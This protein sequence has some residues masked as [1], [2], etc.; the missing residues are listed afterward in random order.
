MGKTP[1]EFIQDSFSPIIA[2]LCS[3]KVENVVSKNNLSFTELL[4]PFTTMDFEG[5][6]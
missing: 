1:Q 5:I 2:I 3:P 4:Q 6:V